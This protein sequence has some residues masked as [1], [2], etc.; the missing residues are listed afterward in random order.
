MTVVI[1]KGMKKEDIDKA[2]RKVS[3]K[4]RL[5]NAKKYAGTVKSF[6]GLDALKYQKDSRNE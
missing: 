3:G 1:K 2:V 4:A 5:I 6:S